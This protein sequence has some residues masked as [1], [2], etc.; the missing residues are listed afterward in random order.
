MGFLSQGDFVPGG[1]CQRD[2][3]TGGFCHRGVLSVHLNFRR[4]KCPHNET[5]VE[6]FAEVKSSGI[7]W[8]N[9]LEFVEAK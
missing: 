1:F 6:S 3:V 7:S 5:Y 9:K 8:A 4:N 2:F